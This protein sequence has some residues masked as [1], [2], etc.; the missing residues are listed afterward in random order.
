MS[1]G[2]AGTV[3]SV[4]TK[5]LVIE[6][7]PTTLEILGTSLVAG[8]YEVI[9]APTG[10][11]GLDLASARE[12]DVVLLDLGLPDIDGLEVCRN[13]RRWF[14]NP[15]IV[16][17]A[18]GSEARKIAAL[19]GGADDYVT[20]PFSVPELLARV[21]VAMRH[22]ALVASVVGSTVLRL[23]DL[24]LDTGARIVTLGGTPVRLT[25]RE[26]D[27]LELLARNPGRVVT[28]GL[29]H[30]Q[31]WGT[32]SPGNS[33]SLR[34]LVS[35]LRSKLGEGSNRPVLSGEPGV[36]YRLNLPPTFDHATDQLEILNIPDASG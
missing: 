30:D 24:E 16:V 34:V 1:A 17:S 5:V 29:I 22:R 20:K 4:L 8:G 18:D 36:G 6:D 21:R 15:I 26:F 7:D 23:A 2:A 11:I 33:N 35:I 25:K 28:H 19:D 32:S 31:L 14:L 9:R 3:R 13:L 10:A 12:P 27:L